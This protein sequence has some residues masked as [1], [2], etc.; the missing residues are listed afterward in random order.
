[1]GRLSKSRL[2]VNKSVQAALSAIELYNKPNFSYREESFCILMVNAWE[3]LLKARLIDEQGESTIYIVDND[4]KKKNGAPYK[5]PKLKENRSGNKCTIDIFGAAKKL[6]L[7]KPLLEQL[8]TAVE[9]RDNAIHFFNESKLFERKLLE[10]GTATLKSY[11][12]LLIE[13][14]D[15]PLSKHEIFLIPVAL[16]IP[17]TFDANSIAK[18]ASAH[19][20]LLQ[21]IAQQEDTYNADEAHR[22]T[23]AVDIKLNRNTTGIPTHNTKDGGHPIVVDSEEKF[24]NLYKWSYKEH[25]MPAL[26][27]RYSDFKQ[28]GNFFKIKKDLEADSRFSAE[29]FLDWNNKR[30]MKKRFYSPNIL[31]EFDKYYTKKAL[32][33]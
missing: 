29:R 11:V 10:V 17:A 1:M 18:E 7:P 22:I 15:Y 4:K 6:N 23:W 20:K 13:W 28:D 14:F 33:A 19:K 27:K 32:A 31:S 26:K 21:Y 16:N 24:Q 5:K 12:D 9:I 3:L 8:E 25:L 30:G 2:L